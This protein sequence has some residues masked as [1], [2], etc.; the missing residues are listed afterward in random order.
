MK[1]HLLR[2]VEPVYWWLLAAGVVMVL[3]GVCRG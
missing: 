3:L 2:R 1:R